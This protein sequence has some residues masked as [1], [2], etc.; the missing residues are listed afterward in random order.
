MRGGPPAQP[1]PGTRGARQTAPAPVVSAPAPSPKTPSSGGI[2]QN[3]L[4][5]PPMVAPP[6]VHST[7]RPNI[8][9]SSRMNHAHAQSFQIQGPNIRPGQGQG[10]DQPGQAARHQRKG[11]SQQQK[12]QQIRPQLPTPPGAGP[13]PAGSHNQLQIEMPGALAALGGGAFTVSTS[14]GKVPQQQQGQLLT[15]PP[16]GG[17]QLAVPSLVPPSALIPGQINGNILNAAEQLKQLVSR[18]PV[19][20]PTNNITNSNGKKRSR[21]RRNPGNN[22]KHVTTHVSTA[23]NHVAT[24]ANQSQQTT[25]TTTTLPLLTANQF[26]PDGSLPAAGL[27]LALPLAM[28]PGR[29]DVSSAALV[30]S[31]NGAT[32]STP[33][34]AVKPTTPAKRPR[35]SSGGASAKKQKT[36]AKSENPVGT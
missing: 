18:S 35:G 20:M 33:D 36:Q 12:Q 5:S 1:P 6:P 13:P 34:R 22:N 26:R 28:L 15:S 31:V 25:T 21:A 11:S 30:T 16:P 2:V 10:Q 17:P 29:N 23:P 4:A 8:L 3:L 32:P 19:S 14:G 9:Q 27:K 7:H 24:T